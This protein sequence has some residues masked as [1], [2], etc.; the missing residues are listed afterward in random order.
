[1][2]CDFTVDQKAIVSTTLDGI[3]NVTDIQS[4]KQT[5]KFDT[6][7]EIE[8]SG[9][10]IQNNIIYTV[11]SL[12]N[13]PDGGNKFAIGADM[14]FIN[15]CDY[16]NSRPEDIRLQTFGKYVGHYNSVRHIDLSPDYKY[17]LSASED[18]SIFL[19]QNDTFKPI[20]ILAGH[21]DL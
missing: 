17:M 7:H 3:I 14:R 4:T 16:D 13:H 15:C 6:I 8:E 21:T 9:G 18:H 1:M 11:K 19:W 5:V 10:K 20:N 2:K 12:K